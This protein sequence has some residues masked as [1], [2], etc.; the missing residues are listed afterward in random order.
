MRNSTPNSV[1]NTL[2]FNDTLYCCMR[3]GTEHH[4]MKRGDVALK[5]DEALQ[6]NYL[7]YYE[8]AI[9]TR[10]GDDLTTSR[11]C[12]LARIQPPP[13]QDP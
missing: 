7:E 11:I 12:P 13:P 4:T 3:G 1:K 6:L 9:N 8:R 5:R 2:W 10:T